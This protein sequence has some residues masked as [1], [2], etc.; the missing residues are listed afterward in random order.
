MAVAAFFDIDGTLISKNTG[1]LYM[2][3]LRQRGE[4][5]RRDALRTVYLY[6]RYKLVPFDYVVAIVC[7]LLLS[8]GSLAGLRRGNFGRGD[9]HFALLGLGFLLLETKSI[10][11]CSL[12][13]GATWLVTVIVVTGVLLMVLGAN[14]IATRL[15]G[16][17]LWMYAPLFAALAV[18]VFVP[19]EAILAFAYPGRLLWALVVVPLPILFAGL[20]FSTTFRLAAVPSGAFGANLIGAMIGGFC[21]YLAMSVGSLR[22]SALIAA[23]YL[24][25]MLLLLIARRENRAL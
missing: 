23:A 24:L 10:T 2:K 17:S 5:R 16:F 15:A 8:V 14:L 22:L 1:P 9:L 4:I 25:S 21:E 6:L 19:R 11:D 13:F 12:Y 7:L 18:L 3:F 20:I